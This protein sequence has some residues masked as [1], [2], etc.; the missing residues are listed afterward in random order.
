MCDSFYEKIFSF[1]LFLVTVLWFGDFSFL[2][3]F[4]SRG[5]DHKCRISDL[6]R[7]ILGKRGT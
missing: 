2:S 1:C 5:L 3:L 4:S 6:I 7:I